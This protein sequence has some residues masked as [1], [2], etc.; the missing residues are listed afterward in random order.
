MS[1]HDSDKLF[2]AAFTDA[3]EFLF[4]DN[5]FCVRVFDMT[6]TTLYN[7]ITSKFI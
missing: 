6:Y 4:P 1:R 2:D 5:N 3:I 7:K